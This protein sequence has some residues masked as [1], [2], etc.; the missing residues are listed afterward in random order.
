MQEPTSVLSALTLPGPL[1]SFDV[2]GRQKLARGAPL[3]DLNSEYARIHR[4]HYCGGNQNVMTTGG[5]YLLQRRLSFVPAGRTF[6]KITMSGRSHIFKSTSTR[7][8]PS[9][10]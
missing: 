5:W 6:V 1:R 7:V 9:F 3:R 2:L 10:K 8:H 4:S